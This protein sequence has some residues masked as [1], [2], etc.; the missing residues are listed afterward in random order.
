MQTFGNFCLY[1][2]DLYQQNDLNTSYFT[3]CDASE[4]ETEKSEKEFTEFFYPI[5]IL[6]SAT[7]MLITLI[8]FWMS[9]D[10]RKLSSFL[11]MGFLV[12]A[13]ICYVSL[14]VHYFTYFFY[15]EHIIG[16]LFCKLLGYVTHHTL[17]AFFFW[18]SAMAINI[19][20]TFSQIKTVR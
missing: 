10:R 12:N 15:D 5:S 20:R 18:T 17:I 4:T 13:F 6:I 14:S 2:T 16:T 11:T 3:V 8:H 1:F 7:F 19:A 9:E